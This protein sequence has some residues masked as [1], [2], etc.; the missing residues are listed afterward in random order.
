MIPTLEK[1]L[2]LK[3]T[4]FFRDVPSEELVHIALVCEEVEFQAG[5]LILQEGLMLDAMY[6]ILEGHV[7][8]TKETKEVVLIAPQETI[9]EFAF[10]DS[11]PV[12]LSFVAKEDVRA[13]RLHREDFWELLLSKSEVTRAVVR[14]LVKKIRASLGF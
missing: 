14:L 1:V 7:Q 11:E 8:L 12:L 4:V 3:R 13:L 9:G 5:Q 6:I 2:A 10:L